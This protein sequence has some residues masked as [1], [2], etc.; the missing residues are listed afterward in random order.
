[1]ASVKV[2][3]PLVK[4]KVDELFLNWL[5]DPATLSNLY[6]RLD[7]IKNGYKADFMHGDTK[8]KSI[9]ALNE[10]NNVASRKILTE[11][12][13][14]PFSSPIPPSPNLL[15]SGIGG[16]AG[17]DG[18]VLQKSLRRKVKYLEIKVK[19]LEKSGLNGVIRFLYACSKL[20]IILGL[21]ILFVMKRLS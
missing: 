10:N 14:L 7:C 17:P 8:E 18:R 2:L 19:H 5:S 16:N 21:L 11:K 13:P 3:Q 6:D 4:M 1:M 15:S 12:K 20:L 9:L